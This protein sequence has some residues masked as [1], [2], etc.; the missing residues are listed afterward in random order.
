LADG[1]GALPIEQIRPGWLSVEEYRNGARSLEE[2]PAR[3]AT[4]GLAAQALIFHPY[5]VEDFEMSCEGLGQLRGQPAWQVHFR[6]RN[7]RPSRFRVYRVKQVVYPVKLKGR[8]WIATDT[9]QVV[10]LET[11]LAEEI[12]AIV[13]RGLREKRKV[14]FKPA[15]LEEAFIKIVGGSIESEDT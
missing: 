13:E 7:D 3:I 5:Y 8:A 6:Q 10:R 9:L 15:S 2:F 11:D 12:L 14:T 4:S 1:Y